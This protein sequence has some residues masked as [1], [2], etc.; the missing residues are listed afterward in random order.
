MRCHSGIDKL[1]LVN[2][3]QTLTSAQKILAIKDFI[4]K[5]YDDAEDINDIKEEIAIK[6]NNVQLA[7]SF[8]YVKD[9]DGKNVKIP[10]NIFTDVITLIKSKTGGV[11]EYV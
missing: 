6:E 7:P 2:N 10:E 3:I 5:E 1:K 9:E 11:L 4:R 8:P